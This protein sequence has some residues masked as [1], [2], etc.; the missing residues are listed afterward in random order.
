M[1]I[2]SEQKRENIVRRVFKWLKRRGVKTAAYDK[3]VT[4]IL[5]ALWIMSSISLIIGGLGTPSGFGMIIDLIVYTLLHTIVFLTVTFAGGFLLA[6]FYVPLPRLLLAALFYSSAITYYILSEANLSTLFSGVITAVW[7]GA[8]LC[9]GLIL[10]IVSHKNWSTPKKF[11]LIIFPLAYILVIFLWSPTIE[12][13]S[14]HPTFNENDYITPLVVPNPAEEGSYSFKSFSYGNGEDKHRDTFNKEVDIVSESVDAS[15]FINE[16]KNYREFFWG[17][18]ET[19]LPLNGRVWMPEGEGTFPLVLIVHGNHSMEYFSDAGYGYLGELLASR[20]YIAVSVDQNFLNYS[21]WTGIPNEDMTLRAWILMKHLLEIQRF[22]GTAN[23]PFFEKVDMQRVSLIGHS[24][25]GQAVAMVA[26][27]ERW[28]SDDES[29]AG[30]ETIDVK[31]VIAIAPTDT[32]VDDMRAEPTNVSYLTLHGARDGDVHNYH[33]D[34]QYS[35]VAIQEGPDFFKAGVYIAEANHSQFNTDWGRMD[36]RLPGGLFLNRQQLMPAEEQR[37]VAKVYIS[38]FLETTLNGNDQYKPLF[39]DARYGKDWLPNTQYVT[40]YED[41]NFY[42]LVDYNE[43]N[44]KTVLSQYIIAE[45]IGFESWE[46]ESAVNRTGNTKRS[47]G[48][49]F[50]WEDNA[51]YVM[52]LD[53]NLRETLSNHNFESMIVSLANMD[54]DFDEDAHDFSQVPRVEVVLETS[55]GS[56]TRVAMDQFKSIQPS[57]FTQYTINPWFDEIMREG[58][59][60]EAVEPVFQNYEL[61]LD[62]FYEQAPDIKLE[63]VTTITF[64]FLEGPGKLMMDNV[65]FYQSN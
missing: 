61:P 3:K 42:P 21:N 15:Q 40:R 52:S 22:N 24:R 57:I 44:N 18:D 50:E 25:G 63:D 7:M 43:S 38:A 53:E 46:I 51:S 10:M 30:M 34:R 9:L 17:F 1:L 58:K 8:A 54:R 5:V 13:N 65:G 31:S 4:Y 32:Q 14:V 48:M 33:G 47:K 26:D 60:E 41:A 6:L 11:T 23:N 16:W 36:M 49:V 59:Y 37:E 20:G 56:S 39:K 55:D 19:A 35:R 45:G 64:H 28:F 29:V 27:Y 12:Y 62:A 2:E